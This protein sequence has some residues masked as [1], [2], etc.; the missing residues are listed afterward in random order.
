MGTTLVPHTTKE[1]EWIEA[2]VKAIIRRAG[3]VEA[4]ASGPGIKMSDLPEL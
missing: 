3:Q 1:I 4:N 2:V